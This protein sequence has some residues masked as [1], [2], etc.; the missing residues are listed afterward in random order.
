[1]C[2]PIANQVHELVDIERPISHARI[3]QEANREWLASRRG[4]AI[5]ERERE[6]ADIRKRIRAWDQKWAERK[7]L[8]TPKQRNTVY[9][10][11]M[12]LSWQRKA[13][14]REHALYLKK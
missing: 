6:L 13:L 2:T 12:Q 14:R 5:F 4:R 3:P 8:L 11:R 9:T 7:H 1:M 10:E